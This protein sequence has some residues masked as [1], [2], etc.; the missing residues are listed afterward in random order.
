MRRALLALAVVGCGGR[1]AAPKP[2]PPLAAVTDAALAAVAV[3][4]GAA[5]AAASDAAPVAPDAS[6][7]VAAGQTVRIPDDTGELVVAVAPDWKAKTATLTHWRRAA[8]GPWER[9]GAPWPAV[10]GVG[11]VAWG[12]GLHGDGA[13]AGRGGP[14]KREGDGKSPAGI[15]D[16]AGTYG[17]A[18]TAPAGARVPYTQTTDH[19]RC[20]DDPASAHYNQIVDDT[21][22][23]SDWS[24]AED[25]KRGDV[26]YDWVV[27]VRHNPGATPG[28][29]SCIFLHVWR[30]A[31]GVTVGCTAMAADDLARLI[32]ALDP[33]AHPRFVLLP[34]AEYAALADAWGLPTLP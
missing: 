22:V 33:A 4:A 16:L 2:T 14:T 3:D 21:A 9:V 13:P 5:V 17:V 1:D 19:A 18:A 7:G 11:G 32:A 30:N 10:I 20:V 15:F 23:A 27:D 24:S 28:G 25:L 34:A 29:G 26:Q 12:R 8:G 6:T 31:K